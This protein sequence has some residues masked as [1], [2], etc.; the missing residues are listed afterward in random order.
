MNMPPNNYRR[1]RT[2]KVAVSNNTSDSG[3]VV[4]GMRYVKRTQL[5]HLDQSGLR[6]EVNGRRAAWY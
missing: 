4:R 5:V 2:T 6:V 3:G 1:H